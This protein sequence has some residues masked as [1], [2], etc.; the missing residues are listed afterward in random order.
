MTSKPVK[1]FRVGKPF[2]HRHVATTFA[3]LTALR[4]PHQSEPVPPAATSPTAYEPQGG[5]NRLYTPSPQYL[6][7]EVSREDFNMVRQLV[8]DLRPSEEND[9]N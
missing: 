7:A 9:G 1:T 5:H 8:L 4:E 3:Y 2:G 6:H